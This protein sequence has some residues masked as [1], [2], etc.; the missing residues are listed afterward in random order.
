MGGAWAVA[1][2]EPQGGG[3]EGAEGG[4]ASS[5]TLTAWR[6][7]VLGRVVGSHSWSHALV[8]RRADEE[9][10]RGEGGRLCSPSGVYP[11]QVPVP[12]GIVSY[13]TCCIII[14]L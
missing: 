11:C 4:G 13:E 1:L 8:C 2:G 3:I 14:T 10:D 7:Q 9:W 5:L 6:R 12:P